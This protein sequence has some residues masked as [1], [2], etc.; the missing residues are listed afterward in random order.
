MNDLESQA[1]T[2]LCGGTVSPWDVS[3][4]LNGIP[5]PYLKYNRPKNTFKEMSIKALQRN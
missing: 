4:K 5:F 3:D 2:I 1:R